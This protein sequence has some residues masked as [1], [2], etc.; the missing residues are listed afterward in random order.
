MHTFIHAYIGDYISFKIEM[1]GQQSPSSQYP[2]QK[3]RSGNEIN[4]GFFVSLINK[5]M[6]GISSLFNRFSTNGCRMSSGH[7]K[8]SFRYGFYSL[9]NFII[10]LSSESKTWCCMPVFACSIGYS[11]TCI[12]H[13][14]SQ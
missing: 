10:K 8:S 14:I 1:L 3:T 2:T 7:P 5:T 13:C 4:L 12:L 11:C 6:N 9:Q